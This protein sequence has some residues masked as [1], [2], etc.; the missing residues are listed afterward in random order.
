MRFELMKLFF[1]FP[2]F[3]SGAINHSAI[4]PAVFVRNGFE[5]LTF[6]L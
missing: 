4:S 2:D 5:P 3:K 6:G 1:N